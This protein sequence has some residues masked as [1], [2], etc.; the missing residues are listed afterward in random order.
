[1]QEVLK[2]LD[3]P[4]VLEVLEVLEDRGRIDKSPSLNKWTSLVEGWALT[5]C[6]LFRC[7]I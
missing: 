7:S 6:C 1:M 5:K 3:V 2:V 4:K